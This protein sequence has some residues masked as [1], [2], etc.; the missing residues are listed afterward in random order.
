MTHEENATFLFL[1]IDGARNPFTRLMESLMY[2][3]TTSHSTAT[4][5]GVK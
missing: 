2:D 5:A 1:D 3:Q 4:Q